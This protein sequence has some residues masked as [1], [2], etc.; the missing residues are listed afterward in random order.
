LGIAQ[1][2]DRQ[3]NPMT[4]LHCFARDCPVEDICAAM[5]IAVKDLFCIQPGYAREHRS[6]PRTRSARIERL[7]HAAAPLT[8]DEI[9]LVMLEEMIVS[10][11]Q[12][13]QD[14]AP[15]RA[16]MWEL[17]QASPRARAQLSHALRQAG[18]NPE[19]FWNTLGR[20]LP[21]I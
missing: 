17:A 1:G 4:L 12:W 21:Q 14:C 2:R 3:G 7:R 15:A 20:N 10:D 16:K 5:G 18:F 6:A 11:P 13:I 9:A 19:L 8:P